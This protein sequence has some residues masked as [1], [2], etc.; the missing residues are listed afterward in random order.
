LTLLKLVAL[1]N[2]ER[3]DVEVGKRGIS[4]IASKA[5]GLSALTLLIGGV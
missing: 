2:G 1:G 4:F 5:R 3:P